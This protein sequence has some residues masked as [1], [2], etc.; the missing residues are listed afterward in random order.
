MKFWTYGIV[1]EGGCTD[2]VAWVG[3]VDSFE[4]CGWGCLIFGWGMD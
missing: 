4:I 2:D 3:H 1:R